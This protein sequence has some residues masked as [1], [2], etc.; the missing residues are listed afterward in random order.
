M[1]NADYSS[2]SFRLAPVSIGKR[3][4]VGNNVAYPAGGRTG[5][6]CLLGTKVMVPVDGPIREN[7]GLLGSPPFEI[8][9]SVH[10]GASS[11]PV[12]DLGERRRRRRLAA[13]NRHN[14]RT[15]VTV[16]FL[17]WLQFFVILL[18]G[19]IAADLYGDV[20]VWVVPAAILLIPLFSS[21]YSALLER[22]VLGFRALRP[23]FCSIYDR[24]FWGHERLWKVYTR[25]I[26]V[27]T[28]FNTLLWR[29]AGVRIGRRVFDDGC[30]LPEKS[31]TA[32]GDDT[33]LNAGSVIQ[34]HSLEDGVFKSDHSTIGAG[35]T[36]GVG[37]FVHY[38]V[39]MGDGAELGADAYLMK[40]EEIAPATRWLGNPARSAAG[41]PLQRTATATGADPTGVSQDAAGR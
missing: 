37:A 13:K 11:G 35:C 34:C 18:V 29:L 26:F 4:F 8:P 6:N 22:A 31:L 28:P 12:V 38:G 21:V 33:V 2:T 3:N 19:G 15:I 16:L 14:A 41:A 30:V 25:P 36:V 10:H 7:V 23:R 24:Y 9:R 20:S 5:D 27:G 1:M 39:T 40:G 17:R 32:I